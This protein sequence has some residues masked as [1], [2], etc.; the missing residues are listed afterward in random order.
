MQPLAVVNGDAQDGRAARDRASRSGRR[1]RP[2]RAAGAAA[3]G[4]S[5]C[6]ATTP[7]TSARS[8]AARRARPRAGEALALRRGR[9]GRPAGGRRASRPSRAPSSRPAPAPTPRRARARAACTRSRRP[10]SRARSTTSTPSS[11][12]TCACRSAAPGRCCAS[13]SDVHDPRRARTLR[14]ELKWAQA[15]TGPV[16]DLDVQLLEWHELVGAAAARARRRARA[17]AGAARA[18]AARA[19]SRSCGAACAARASRPRC[20]RGTRSRPPRR[21]RTA[22]AGRRRA[23]S[24]RW[25]AQRIRKVYRRIVRDGR[26]IDDDSPPEA[27]HDLR[28]RGKELRYLLELFGSPFPT[29]VVKPMVSTLK[30]LQEVLGRFQDRAVQIEPLRELRDELAARARRARGAARARARARRAARRPGGRARAVRRALRGLRRQRAA[31]ASSATRSRSREGRRHLLDQG[32]RRE[33]V[34]GG[35]PGRA[36]RPRRPADADL[37]PRPAG[38]RVVPVPGRAE[39]QGRGQAADP[40]QARAARRDEGHRHRGPRPAAGRL[41]LPPPRHPARPAQEAAGG[42]S[43]ACSPSSTDATTW[44]SSTARR[45]SRSSPRACSRAADLLLVPLIPS[46]LSVRTFEQLRAF[47]AAGPQPA[48]EVLAFF[49]MV[50]RRKNLHRE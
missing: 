3:V 6:S 21:S 10:T 33:D 46:T 5:R 48:P 42:R 40:R 22:T 25:P 29:S 14:D 32:R 4:A 37:G 47:L 18:R 41:L 27:L 7:P 17:A 35:Q 44:R 1:Q 20:A 16:R 8:R 11:C 31:G 30:D 19:S 38:R 2:A 13:S 34:R 50:D 23:R 12:T 49:S 45:R 24:R 26:R 36:G 9:E 15:L 43:A 39:G 28:K